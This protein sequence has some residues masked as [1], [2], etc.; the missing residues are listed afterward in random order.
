MAAESSLWS[1]GWLFGTASQAGE[2]G[3]LAEAK[4]KAPAAPA[5]PSEGAP[6]QQGAETPAPQAEKTETTNFENWILNCREFVEGPK[7]RSCAMTV[8]VRKS[9]TNRV[10]LSWTVRPNDKGQLMSIVETLPG[11]SIPPGI[12]LKFEKSSATKTI[13]IEVCEPAWC[14]GSLA[15][16]KAFIQEASASGK[17]MIVITSSTG[18]PVQFEFPIKGFEKAY[19]KM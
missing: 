17:V 8:S 18:Q 13:P 1:T 11:I 10:V 4:Q 16:D 3:Q 2:T 7:K 14:A 19:A 6:P 12:Q 9:D 5:K 15:M